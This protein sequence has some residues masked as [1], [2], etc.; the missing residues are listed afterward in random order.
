MY[1]NTSIGH[2]QL[3]NG[4]RG[5]IAITQQKGGDCFCKPPFFSHFGEFSPQKKTLVHL[6]WIE[7]SLNDQG[8]CPPI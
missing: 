5:A 1:G 4:V 2:H 3:H 8:G 6:G 7:R